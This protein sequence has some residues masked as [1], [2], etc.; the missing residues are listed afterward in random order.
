MNDRQVDIMYIEAV[1]F[2]SERAHSAQIMHTAVA[3]ANE[4]KVVELVIP[5]RR[6]ALNVDPFEY[7]ALPKNDR[8][9]LTYLSVPDT[10][11]LGRLGFW[12]HQWRF[13]VAAR[14]HAKKVHPRCIYSRDESVLYM[15]RRLPSL[16]VWE[17][18][19]G[20]FNFFVYRI[21]PLLR[22]IVVI[23][24]G[25]KDSYVAKGISP[26]K[27]V[28]AHDGIVLSAFRNPEEKMVARKRL[29]LPLDEKIAMY[30]GSLETWKGYRTFL[31]ASHIAQNVLFVVIGGKDDNLPKLRAAHPN[32]RFLGF[33]PYAELPDNQQ[34]ADVL[35][36][37][38]T[39]N[40]EVS[41][42]FTSP[43]KLFAH[44]AS[45]IPIV[46]SDLPSIR[47]IV[48]D[49]S[50]ILVVPDDPLRLAEGIQKALRDGSAK[51]VRAKEE[52]LEYVWECRAKRILATIF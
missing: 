23:S 7:Y 47:E 19:L 14:L 12:Y 10:V 1:R 32:V 16:L 44:M 27:I 21:I 28:V 26:E 45:G 5:R 6:L 33:R 43:L 18:H 35:V 52:V 22:S 41:A 20:R 3:F 49:E 42:R 50:A 37:P 34:A 39:A 4:G 15:L 29:G 9:T 36:V 31:A 11:T 13:G 17:S 46:A 24:K 48:S 30:I 25:L 38:N 2:P 8:L 40:D 51:S